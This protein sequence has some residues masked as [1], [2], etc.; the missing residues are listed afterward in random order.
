VVA[1]GGTVP[2]WLT[3]PAVLVG[4]VGPLLLGFV[5]GSAVGTVVKTLLYVALRED[6]DRLPVVNLP[7][8]RVVD[9]LETGDGPGTE[10]AAPGAPEEA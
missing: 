10:P 2:D 6:C 4:A 1:N 5:Y 3:H 7:V 9:D 8:E